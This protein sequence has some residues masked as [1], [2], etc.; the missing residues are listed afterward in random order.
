MN[1]E[2][3]DERP[4][5]EGGDGDYIDAII[6]KRDQLKATNRPIDPDLDDV[7]QVA[8]MSREQL[9]RGLRNMARKFAEDRTENRSLKR[10][11]AAYPALLDAL[12]AQEKSHVA[13][14]R[15]TA[16]KLNAPSP[17]SEEENSEGWKAELAW[18]EHE[19]IELSQKA[20][21]LRTAALSSAQPEAPTE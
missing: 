14:L 11:L 12:K 15:I 10:K 19:F 9:E 2:E 16:H 1:Q 8:K 5:C 4:K 20:E 7:P 18:L 17:F 6:E 13:G 21:A 3:W